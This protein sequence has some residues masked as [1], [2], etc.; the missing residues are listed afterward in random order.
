MAAEFPARAI[1]M[2]ARPIWTCIVRS[3]FHEAHAAV[4]RRWRPGDVDRC[5]RCEACTACEGVNPDGTPG[6][7]MVCSVLVPAADLVQICCD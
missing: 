5:G 1:L 2:R 4:I 3:R 6:D 7:F